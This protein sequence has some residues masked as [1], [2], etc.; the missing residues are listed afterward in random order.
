M[1]DK[2]TQIRMLSEA[3]FDTEKI[4]LALSVTEEEIAQALNAPKNEPSS[5][6]VVKEGKKPHGA[7]PKYTEELW[8]AAKDMRKRGFTLLEIAEKQGFSM[9]YISKVLRCNNYEEVI[10]YRKL[11]AEKK[12]KYYS[13]GNAVST[14]KQPNAKRNWL[15]V[16]EESDSKPVE[17]ATVKKEELSPTLIELRTMNDT[18]LRIAEALEKK[19]GLFHR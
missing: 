3:G 2:N 9:G 7:P 16:D 8:A 4:K 5:Q 15:N 6:M 19:R 11:S 13:R 18:L 1:K 12:R 14:S 17:S 10:A